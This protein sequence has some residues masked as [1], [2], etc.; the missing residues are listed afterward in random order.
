MSLTTK[1]ISLALSSSS[2]Y[3]CCV[4]VWRRKMSLVFLNVWQ[5]ALYQIGPFCSE[6]VPFC[7]AAAGF[8]CDV[9]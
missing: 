9:V 7:T 4:A 6:R 5:C 8:V 2:I 3:I 1:T